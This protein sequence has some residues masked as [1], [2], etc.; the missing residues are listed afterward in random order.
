[1]SQAIE[2]KINMKNIRL[3]YSLKHLCRNVE[4]SDSMNWSWIWYHLFIYKDSLPNPMLGVFKIIAFDC[5]IFESSVIQ[6][7]SL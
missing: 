1:M 5:L 7:L 2:L 3:I 4:Y 6:Y